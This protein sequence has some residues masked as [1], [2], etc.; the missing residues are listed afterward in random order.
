MWAIFGMGPAELL[1][2]LIIAGLILGAFLAIPLGLVALAILI[3]RRRK[4][5]R[6]RL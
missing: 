3:W 2:V 4:P 6:D 1:V 5:P